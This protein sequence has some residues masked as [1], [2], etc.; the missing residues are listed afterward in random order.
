MFWVL[1]YP[2]PTP[3]IRKTDL[4]KLGANLSGASLLGAKLES[5]RPSKLGTYLER[6]LLGV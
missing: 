6:C 5:D 2:G 1:C 4:A 3:E